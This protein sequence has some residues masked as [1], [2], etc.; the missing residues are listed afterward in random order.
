[1]DLKIFSLV[2]DARD[3][4]YEIFDKKVRP[5]PKNEDGSF[6]ITNAF[7]DNDVDAFRHAYVSG[8]V[9]QDYSERTA[10]ILG[11]LNELTPSASGSLNAPGSE[12]MDLWNNAV[13]RK[14]G[15]ATKSRESLTTELLQALE[16]GELI[17]DPKDTRIYQGASNFE[18]DPLRPVIVILESK[19]GR[20]EEFFDTIKRTA[21]PREEFVQRI[22]EGEYPG[23]SVKS[24]RDLEYPVSKSDRHTLNNLG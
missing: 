7:H 18:I 1:M 9:T 12:N 14:Y 13:G 15:K 23:Y 16:N 10:D 22:K 8:V 17:V 11:Q 5:L 21:F 4:S 2:N 3:E 6:R 24:V 20:N 19:K